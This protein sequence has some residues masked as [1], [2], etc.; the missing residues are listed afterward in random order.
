MFNLWHDVALMQT[1]SRLMAR[2]ALLMLL[3]AGGMWILQRPYFAINQFRFVGDVKQLEEAQLNELVKKNLSSGLAGGFF[4][5]ELRDVQASL[6]EI[7]WIKNAS[8]RRVWPHEVEVNVEAYKPVAVW[9]NRYL[10]AEGQLFDG[11]LTADAKSKLL[12][13]SGPDAAAQLVAEQIPVLQ[14]WFKPM[15]TIKSVA[16]SER[17]SWKVALSNGLEVELGRADTPTV[18]EE[19]AARL[20]N[21]AQ[22]IQEHMDSAG[23]VDLRY[24]NG[25][26][27]RSDKLHRTASATNNI[28]TGEQ[29]D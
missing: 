1:V 19:R 7:T 15:G 20:V 21:S 17:Y 14:N 12:T 9:G 18:L 4:S 3:V 23:Y 11:V 2:V 10:S 26:A 22:F 27:M 8:I 24:P 28:K 5:M 25:F 29:H 13:T 16:L 6:S